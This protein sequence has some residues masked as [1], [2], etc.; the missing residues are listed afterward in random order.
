MSVSILDNTTTGIT[1]S[2]QLLGR[3][4][5]FKLAYFSPYSWHY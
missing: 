1:A 5:T 4:Q 3:F 2:L